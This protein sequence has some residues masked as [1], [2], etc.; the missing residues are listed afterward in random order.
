MKFLGSEPL[1]SDSGATY[2]PGISDRRNG[3]STFLNSGLKDVAKQTEISGNVTAT[4]S[5]AQLGRS[6]EF[7]RV[8]A[9]SGDKQISV[10]RWGER[11]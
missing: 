5:V 3:V 8:V 10:N 6:E 2:T 7:L 9:I 1:I 4:K 11:P